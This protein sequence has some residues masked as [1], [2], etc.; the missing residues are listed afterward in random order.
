MAALLTFVIAS[1]LIIFDEKAQYTIGHL[2]GIFTG[3]SL[4]L[5]GMIVILQKNHL[6]KAQSD[7]VSFT[8]AIY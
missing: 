4:C 2:V 3:M 8:S 5:L 1:G 6:I 7:V